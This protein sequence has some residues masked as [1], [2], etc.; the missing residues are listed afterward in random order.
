M[1]GNLCEKSNLKK[2][3]I[4]DLIWHH[5][6]FVLLLFFHFLLDEKNWGCEELKLLWYRILSETTVSPM[7]TTRIWKWRKIGLNKNIYTWQFLDK[8]IN[9]SF[10]LRKLNEGHTYYDNPFSYSIFI[11]L[12]QIQIIHAAYHCI[13]VNILLSR[14]IFDDILY[15]VSEQYI[16]Y[17]TVWR[18]LPDRMKKKKKY[19]WK[20]Y[21]KINFGI[22]FDVLLSNKI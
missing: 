15:K 9:L 22:Q 8:K 17:K 14:S 20:C 3:Y 11:L 6:Q 21:L 10:L 13:I 18:R 4:S 5:L 7:K 12:T 19:L 16:Y 2:V 1:V